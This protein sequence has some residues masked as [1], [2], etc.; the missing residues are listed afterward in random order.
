M[1]LEKTCDTV[2]REELLYEKRW[3][4]RQVQCVSVIRDTYE[5]SQKPSDVQ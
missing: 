1:H 4:D 2:P 5:G 3:G